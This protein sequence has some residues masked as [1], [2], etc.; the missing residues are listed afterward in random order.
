MYETPG[1]RRCLATEDIIS[2]LG[3]CLLSTYSVS[4]TVLGAGAT[5]T[6]VF[7]NGGW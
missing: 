3:K 6:K 5:D 2:A 4:G 7:D 1:A